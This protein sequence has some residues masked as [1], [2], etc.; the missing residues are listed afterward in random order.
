MFTMKDGKLEKVDTSIRRMAEIA[1]ERL[2]I[3]K[4]LLHL[5]YIK[6]LAVPE[7]IREIIKGFVNGKYK[8]EET[9]QKLDAL[10]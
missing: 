2:D 5:L 10:K 8:R 9:I 4:T 3:S 6:N 7:P 1:K